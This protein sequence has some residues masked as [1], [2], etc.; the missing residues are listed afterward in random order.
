[1]AQAKYTCRICGITRHET[2]EEHERVIL[3]SDDR[4]VRTAPDIRT[5]VGGSERFD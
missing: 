1:M 3:H 2:R 5:A 4:R